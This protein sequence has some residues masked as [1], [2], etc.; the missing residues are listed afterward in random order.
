MLGVI[1]NS[2]IY[3]EGVRF[4]YTAVILSNI[5]LPLEGLLKKSWLYWPIY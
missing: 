5:T 4:L 1:F 3:K 2:N